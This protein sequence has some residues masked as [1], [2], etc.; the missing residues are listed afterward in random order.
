MDP[1]VKLAA[2]ISMVATCICLAAVV[3]NDPGGPELP[4]PMGLAPAASAS[5]V[6]TE[7]TEGPPRAAPTASIAGHASAPSDPPSSIWPPR[8]PLGGSVSRPPQLARDY[9]RPSPGSY[10]RPG[11][12]HRPSVA[13][14]SGG[15]VGHIF[16]HN[17][18]PQRRHTIAD[19]DTLPALAQRYLGAP[20]R[21]LEIYECNR[22]VL[23]NPDEL[24]IGTELRIPALR[25]PRSKIPAASTATGQPPRTPLGY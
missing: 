9:P 8:R 13:Q 12:D 4:A 23:H 16:R 22:D 7:A 5:D 17:P 1:G 11:N 19:G 25:I 20:E 6:D 2:V 14:P 21:Y 10:H 24:P 15:Y 18:A 3:F